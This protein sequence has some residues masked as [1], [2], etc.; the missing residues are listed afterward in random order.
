MNNV[1]KFKC[2][3]CGNTEE[4]W[5]VEVMRCWVKINPET[6]E[7]EKEGEVDESYNDYSKIQCGVCELI[8]EREEETE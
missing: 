2:P 6:G 3:E 5:A 8:V 1:P 4:I 7:I